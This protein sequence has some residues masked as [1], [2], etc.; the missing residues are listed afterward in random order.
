MALVNAFGNI[1][2]DSSVNA[3][4]TVLENGARVN[5]ENITT[6]FRE[7]FESYAPGTRW[8][9]SLGSGDLVILDGNSIAASYLV[10]SKDPWTADNVTTITTVDT[11]VM[12]IEL[13][14]GLHMSQ[15]TNG[16]ELAVEL[17]STDTPLSPVDDI[18]ITTISQSGTTLTVNTATPH[19]LV[20]GKRIAISGVADSRFNYPS[21]VVSTI[22]TPTQ[23]LVTAGPWGTIPSITASSSGGVVYFRSALGYAVDGTSMIFEN[24]VATNASVYT[25]SAG[26]DV[27]PSG[28]AQG[29]HSVT[30]NTTA[31]IQG[32]NAAYTYAFQPTSEFRLV[33]QAD[34]LQWFDSA[35]DSTGLT[36]SRYFRTQVIPDPSKQ[37][38]LRFRYTNNKSMT[39]P[40]AQIVSISKSGA[41]TA[42]VNTDVAHGL[43]T[44]DYVNIYGVRDQTNFANL[45]TA[46]V[47]ASTPSST[48]FTVVLGSAVTAT[49]YGGYVAKVNGGNAMSL[50]GAVAQV[51]QTATVTSTELT[52]VGNA[53]WSGLLIGDYVNVSG[54]RNNTN[55]ATMGVDGVYKVANIATTTLTLIP[56]GSTTLPSPFG[57][58]AC[59]GAVIKRTDARISF[60]R[61]FDFLRERVE[62]MP[63]PSGDTSAAIPIQGTIT[64]LPTLGTVTTVSTVTTMNQFAGI[65]NN[66]VVYDSQTTAWASSIRRSVS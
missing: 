49:S 38:K 31:S 23:F 17:I 11:F 48:Q 30:I 16:Q 43:T 54:C 18:S 7:S 57:S 36:T 29:N 42:T 32:V 40:V 61:I 19:G 44:G 62:I 27:L 10:I 12:P 9:E 3:V 2:L 15:R 52:L 66:T 28:T 4:K 63:R 34:R 37:Y 41:T 51:I 56:I 58:T 59:G 50:M 65:P 20:P 13:S 21:L 39:L 46:T 25:R 35:V 26:G 24:T 53:N 8:V 33:L 55:G 1:A 14:F 6:K 22:P 64:A 5:P 45:T 60:A 47:V